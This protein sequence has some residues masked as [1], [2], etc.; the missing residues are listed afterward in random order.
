MLVEI[1]LTNGFRV[2]YVNNLTVIPIELF[3]AREESHLKIVENLNLL[4]VRFFI[5]LRYIQNDSRSHTL[6][7]LYYDSLN[8][9]R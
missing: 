7:P 6:Q 5:P 8:A 3:S 1:S 2:F 9:N 4:W